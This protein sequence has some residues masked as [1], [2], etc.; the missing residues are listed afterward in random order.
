[1]YRRGFEV[2]HN[3]PWNWGLFAFVE[4]YH[5]R[6]HSRIVSM[7]EAYLANDEWAS[8]LVYGTSD[9]DWQAWDRVVKLVNDALWE[10]GIRVFMSNLESTKII[11]G[12]PV[13]TGP[14]FYISVDP[15]FRKINGDVVPAMPAD[16]CQVLFGS[17]KTFD[18]QV[19]AYLHNA[20]WTLVP[21]ASDPQIIHQDYPITGMSHIV[22]KTG[23]AKCT[24]EV[25]EGVFSRQH[26]DTMIEH[27]GW[28][29]D[30]LVS[31]AKGSVVVFRSNLA[32][33]GARTTGVG[34]S[35]TLSMEISSPRGH[36]N[37][38][39]HSPHLA[40]NPE[41]QRTPIIHTTPQSM[42]NS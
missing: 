36:A 20:G 24:T 2:Y 4:D 22:W 31:A 12:Y 15:A 7:F 32:H 21:P 38:M 34:W 9:Y 41:W 1:M 8:S 11:D 18:K 17:D 3:L 37:W 40:S 30:S 10:D 6:Y 27:A 14:R 5:S 42:D 26:L 35:S 19:Q 13:V 29:E 23:G 33:R 16:L 25:V 28:E 39:R